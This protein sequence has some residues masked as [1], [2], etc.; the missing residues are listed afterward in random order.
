MGQT[1][2]SDPLKPYAG[3]TAELEFVANDPETR[4]AASNLSSALGSAGWHVIPRPSTEEIRDGVEVQGFAFPNTNIGSFSNAMIDTEQLAEHVASDV[5]KFLHKYNWAANL[6]YMGR[7]N[8]RFLPQNGIRIR[9]GLY[10][11]VMYV[12]PPAMRAVAGAFAELEAEMKKE[13][14]QR[15]EKTRDKLL[16]KL[17]PEGVAAFKAREEEMKREKKLF[18][19]PYVSPCQ[20]LEPLSPDPN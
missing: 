16:S 9:V 18:L 17:T 12:T 1:S 11:P 15:T 8:T 14:Q 10:P 19:E 2:F 13:A 4:R 6:G 7:N 3:W 20:P 5:L